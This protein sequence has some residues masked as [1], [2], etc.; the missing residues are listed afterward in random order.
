MNKLGA[1]ISLAHIF[2]ENGFD[3]Y[4][5]GGSVRDYLL[6]GEL[7]DIDVVSSATPEEIKKFATFKTDFVYEKFGSVSIHFEGYRIDYTTLREEQSYQDNRHPNE[8]HFVKDIKTDSKRRDF[9]INAMY[10]DCH[11]NV[12]DFHEGQKDLSLKII[13]M[14]GDPIKRIQEDPLRILRAIRFALDFDFQIDEELK[15]S[16]ET[17][18]NL[19][20]KLN[21]DKIHQE[22][23]KIKAPK[24]KIEKIF[25]QFHILN[26]LDMVK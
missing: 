9:T 5:V 22:I 3:L 16:I 4:L 24:E 10:M 15:N 8:V 6:F 11:K 18:L 2:K 21:P 14:I 1:F 20:E 26:Y 7:D 25:S 19:L 12:Y 17:N 13:K 23:H